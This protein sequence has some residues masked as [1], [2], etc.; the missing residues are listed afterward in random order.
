MGSVP[1]EVPR[2]GHGQAGPLGARA[3]VGQLQGGCVVRP[4]EAPGRDPRTVGTRW[5]QRWGH[6]TGG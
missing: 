3:D 5:K 4:G 6:V 2:V 1:P